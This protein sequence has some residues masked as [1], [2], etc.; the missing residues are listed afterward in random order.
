[1]EA[2]GIAGA[3]LTGGR[4]SRMGRDK[5]FVQVAGEQMVVRV[6]A[7]LGGAGVAPVVAVGGDAG[8]LGALGI[9]SIP[10]AWPG[11]GPLGGILTALRWCTLPR[12]CVVACDLGVLTAATITALLD[13]DQSGAAVVAMST[14]LE[15]LC[16]VWRR[17]ETTLATLSGLFSGGERSVER[18]LGALDITTVDVAPADLS[19][20]NAPQDLR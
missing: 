19:N 8:R 15:P 2:A 9:A 16:A 3:I 12:I 10:D 20:F 18:A 13:G 11:E 14:R 1:M 17:D 7:A 6:H 5:A 4:S